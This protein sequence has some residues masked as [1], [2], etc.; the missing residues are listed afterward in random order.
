MK[1]SVSTPI[2]FSAHAIQRY[3]EPIGPAQIRDVLPGHLASLADISTVTRTPPGWFTQ[4][5]K[6]DAPLYLT[7]RKIR[8]RSWLGRVSLMV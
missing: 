8:F 4:S 7:G 5:A 2:T 3:G 1:V 6:E